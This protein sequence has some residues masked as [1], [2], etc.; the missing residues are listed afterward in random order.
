[1]AFQHRQLAAALEHRFRADP[2][3]SKGIKT[4]DGILLEFHPDLGSFPT[5][6][7]LQQIVNVYLALTP[8]ERS[9]LPKLAKVPTTVTTVPPLRTKV[10]EII[11]LLADRGISEL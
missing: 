1:M 3:F 8:R 6:A 5:D 10:N 7:D 4:V 11:Q 2:N 9:T